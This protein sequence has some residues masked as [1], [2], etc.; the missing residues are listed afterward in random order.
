MTARNAGGSASQR[1]APTGTVKASGTQP[2]P[3]NTAAPVLTGT[4]AQGQTLTTTTGAWSNSPS[5]FT[6]QWQDCDGIG[7]NCVAIAAATSSSYAVQATDVG[8]T[9]RSTV[10]ASNAGGSASASSAAT[11][12]VLPSPPSNT[13]LPT[14][15]GTAQQGDVLKAST[16]SWTGS[17][18]S[19]AYQW[20][21]CANGACSNISG[22]TS[23]SYTVQVADIG[24][25]I[26]V[27]VTARN[28][29]GS[30]SQ[31]SAPTGT[32]KASGTQPVGDPQGKAWTLVFDDEFNGTSID[33]TKWDV[34]GPNV[35]DNNSVE[36]DPADC[37]ESGGNLVLDTNNT[38]IPGTLTGCNMASAWQPYTGATTGA[39]AWELAVGDY[40]EARVWVA[41]S[42]AN[43]NDPVANWPAFW[44]A[45][46]H[47]PQNGELDII[48]GEAKATCSYHTNGGS[49]TTD[50]P[51]NIVCAPGFSA[52]GPS[53]VGPIAGWAGA[54]HTYGV[55]RGASGAVFYWDGVPVNCIGNGQHSPTV[56]AACANPLPMTDEGGPQALRF[57]LGQHPGTPE[58]ITGSAGDMLVDW[59]RG[60]TP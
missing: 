27:I 51:V 49:G 8:H 40:V 25:T 48:E 22:A 11:A 38:T 21:R 45:G 15:S 26:E 31:R 39:N 59:V 50:K 29:G 34:F 30:A 18:S 57:T 7:L 52:S 60:Y 9:I 16:G 35:H 13:A 23:S 46:A 6:Y 53:P 20:Q 10:T 41:V 36:S 24:D 42:S 12:V 33:T 47:W 4:P 2:A 32:V 37:S 1:S 43:A 19:F 44:T 56:A 55:Y 5:R 3:V 17:P 54:W 58:T 14:V 28:A